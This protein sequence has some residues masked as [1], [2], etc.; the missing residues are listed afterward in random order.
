V[1]RTDRGSQAEWHP[2]R[3]SW[4][5]SVLTWNEQVDL[6]FRRQD[7]ERAVAAVPADEQAVTAEAAAR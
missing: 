1:E 5:E 2:L 7:H 4:E 3:G 6:S